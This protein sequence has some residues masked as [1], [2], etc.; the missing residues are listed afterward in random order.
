ME[1]VRV[2]KTELAA[3]IR[4]EIKAYKRTK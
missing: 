2:P 4:Q 1:Q 3:R